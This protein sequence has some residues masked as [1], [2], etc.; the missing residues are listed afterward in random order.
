MIQFTLMKE[1]L[2]HSNGAGLKDVLDL[3]IGEKTN[4]GFGK[5][6]NLAKL[7]TED[8]DEVNQFVLTLAEAIIGRIDEPLSAEDTREIAVGAAVH[9]TLFL[10]SLILPKRYY[11]RSV[12]IRDSIED[13]MVNFAVLIATRT[14]ASDGS[15]HG[16]RF[17]VEKVRDQYYQKLE[18]EERRIEKKPRGFVQA[19][20]ELRTPKWQKDQ[21]KAF[22]IVEKAGGVSLLVAKAE[23]L[24]R[25]GDD[26]AIVDELSYGDHV[27]FDMR[28]NFR[29]DGSNGVSIEATPDIEKPVVLFTTCKRWEYFRGEQNLS[30]G[31]QVN[32]AMERAKPF[33]DS[34]NLEGDYSHFITKDR[35]ARRIYPIQE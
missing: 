21:E 2:R 26:T 20:K 1:P 34:R 11:S 19:I 15:V 31:R 25:L 8:P 35:Q 28:W 4:T 32:L 17:E 3:A 6:L 7:I 29:S 5:V 33:H 22:K 14:L 16:R 18:E 24:H 27:M 13:A 30:L 10:R 12:E 23:E 9:T